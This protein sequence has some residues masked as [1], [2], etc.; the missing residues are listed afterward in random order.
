MHSPA[1][2]LWPMK[3]Q[4]YLYILYSSLHDKH[5]VGYSN[6]PYRRLE[7]HNTKPF[8]TFTSKYRPW[9]L[10]AVFIA[11]ADEGTAIELERFIKKQ[12]SRSLLK[13]LTDPSF[14]P[15][16]YLAQMVRVPHPVRT[17]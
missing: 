8:N 4:Y 7:E 11:G 14:I 6:D 3:D 10:A 9:E 2:D 13:K 1:K 5:Y 12:K 17:G 16:G 15:D